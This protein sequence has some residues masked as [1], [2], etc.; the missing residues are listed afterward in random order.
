MDIDILQLLIETANADGVL[1]DQEREH[2]YMRA[3]QMGIDK[4]E[5]DQLIH[6]IVNKTQPSKEDASGFALSEDNAEEEKQQISSGFVTEMPEEENRQIS[7]GFV[8]EMPEEEKQQISS[9]FVTNKQEKKETKPKPLSKTPF[10][11]NL[12]QLSEQGAMSKIYKA[13][14]HNKWVIVKRLKPEHTNDERYKRLFYKEFENTNHLIHPNIVQLYDKGEDEDGLFYYME[15]VDGREL[16][17]IIKPDGVGDDE[18]VRKIILQLCEA[19]SYIH[20][21]QIY[22]RD[23]KPDNI[24]ITYKGNNVKLIDFGLASADYFDDYL[25]KAGTPKYMSPEQKENAAKIDHK[26]DIYSLGLIFLEL[27]TGSTERKAIKKV[28]NSA[29]ASIIQTC[30]KENPTERFRDCNEIYNHLL[31]TEKTEIVPEW[32]L[33]KIKEFAADGKISETEWKILE[34]QAKKNRID[35]EAIKAF[36]NLE[37]EKNREKEQ[38]RKQKLE[39]ERLQKIKQEKERKEKLIKE[40]KDREEAEKRLE[41]LRLK[42]QQESAPKK[43]QQQQPA[44]KKVK[45]KSAWKRLRNWTILILLIASIFY[46]KPQFVFDA[47]NKYIFAPLNER[48][49]QFFSHS[50]TNTQVEVFVYKYVIAHN[51]LNIRSS[52]RTNTEDNIIETLPYGTKVKILESGETWEKVEINGIRGYVSAKFLSTNLDAQ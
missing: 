40:Q 36:V 20:V 49:E 42:I 15:Y 18:L 11:T 32:Q 1:S 34:M 26:A 30:L 46:F 41:R 16:S 19:L 7:S 39:E 25:R 17:K 48:I 12:S 8:T 9:G 51:G 47:L 33:K 13:K 35:L 45:K 3:A 21:K 22:H 6:K 52:K 4:K 5:V 24:L 27:L 37:L 2:I 43:I 10:F 50:S 29:F 14:R 44:Q 28:E 23:L 31:S 38:M